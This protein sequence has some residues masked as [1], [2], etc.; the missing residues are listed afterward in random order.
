MPNND[1]L[2]CRDFLKCTTALP[3]D[4]KLKLL[5]I[6]DLLS[7]DFRHPSLQCKKISGATANVYECR[8]DQQVRLVYDIAGS[9]LRCWY[10]GDHDIALRYGATMKSHHGGV[11]VDDTIVASFPASVGIILKYLADKS[12]DVPF[13]EMNMMQFV[14]EIGLINDDAPNN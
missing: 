14:S 1:V 7:R 13:T 4:I 11:S 2:F 10:V 9:L 8:V 3:K 6:L 5:R 12:I